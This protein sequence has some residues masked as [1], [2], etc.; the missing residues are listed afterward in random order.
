MGYEAPQE[1]R[2]IKVDVEE[3][4]FRDRRDVTLEE[5][6]AAMEWLVARAEQGDFDHIR[7]THEARHLKEQ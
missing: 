4:R 6:H 5:R 2:K 7:R 1:P 3:I